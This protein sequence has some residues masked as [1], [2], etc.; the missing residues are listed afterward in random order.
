MRDVGGKPPAQQDQQVDAAGRRQRVSNEPIKRAAR[1]RHLARPGQASARL[2]RA[3]NAAPPGGAEGKAAWKVAACGQSRRDRAISEPG[4]ASGP[5]AA[6]MPQMLGLSSTLRHI[7]TIATHRFCGQVL[8]EP[9]QIALKRA[10]VQGFSMLP[11][12]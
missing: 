6:G 1:G 2:C 12:L 9:G 7:M 4:R 8:E 10:S 3:P 5:G 11:N